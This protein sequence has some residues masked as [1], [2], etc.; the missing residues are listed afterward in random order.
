MKYV[1]TLLKNVKSPL[2][3]GTVVT[4]Y[5]ARVSTCVRGA[6]RVH[7]TCIIGIYLCVFRTCAG[8][9]F[10]NPNSQHHPLIPSLLKRE[11]NIQKASSAL[12]M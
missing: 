5:R 10:P 1:V 11:T 12:S 4:E 2:E 7:T 3:I 6:F 8:C 9:V